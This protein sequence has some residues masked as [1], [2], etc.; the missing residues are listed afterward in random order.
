MKK[1]F[2]LSIV[3]KL[4]LILLLG[5][6]ISCS[7][8]DE[9]ENSLGES[10][11]EELS[12]TESSSAT[13]I[14]CDTSFPNLGPAAPQSCDDV[15][16]PNNKGTL[17]CRTDSSYGGYSNSGS[18]GKYKIIG[19]SI[20]YNG[21][22]TRVER[23]FN[24]LSRSNNSKTILTGR[25]RIY[26]LSDGNTCII[27][28][29]AGGQIV[30]GVESGQTNRSA[31]F[32]LY[33]RKSGNNIVLETHVTTNPYTTTSGGGR[34]VTNFKTINYGQEYTFRYETG[35][36]SSNIAFSKIKVGGTETNITHNHTTERVYTRY[37][38]YGTSDTG[39]VTAHVQFKDI[40][41]CRD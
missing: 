38:A 39:D 41:H 21:T 4:S 33:A 40:N 9:I 19:G 14:T 28:S 12:A 10:N 34:T 5:I 30:S 17:D 23:F 29:H 16:N 13:G 2:N 36:N 8:N 18:W 25:L 26:D 31:Q 3:K 6:T 24:T 27:Q 7:K 22:K 15:S 1:R 35:Y 32:L 20:R 37:G 11:L